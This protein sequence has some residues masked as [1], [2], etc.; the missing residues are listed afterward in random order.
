MSSRIKS[1]TEAQLMVERRNYFDNKSQG[2]SHVEA[3]DTA[4][5]SN[6]NID[7]DYF[8]IPGAV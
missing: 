7:F 2:L 1:L 5:V 3:E 6:I 8:L 4:L